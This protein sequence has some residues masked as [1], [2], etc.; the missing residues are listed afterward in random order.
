MAETPMHRL[1]HDLLQ[2]ADRRKSIKLPLTRE[3]DGQPDPWF[4]RP[5]KAKPEG[6]LFVGAKEMQDWLD[7]DGEVEKLQQEQVRLLPVLNWARRLP[8][9]SSDGWLIQHFYLLVRAF[10]PSGS[11][12]EIREAWTKAFRAGVMAYTQDLADRSVFDRMAEEE[13]RLA[14]AQDYPENWAD[15]CNRMFGLFAASASARKGRQK[16]AEVIIVPV[17]LPEMGLAETDNFTA[18]V[19]RLH[20]P[21]LV[22]LIGV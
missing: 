4:A 14:H 19:A 16:S 9:A 6:A 7:A 1:T 5:A 11:H 20:H 12:S 22:W 21:R 15:F 8:G 18:A 2:V 3:E 10:C 13:E 17:L